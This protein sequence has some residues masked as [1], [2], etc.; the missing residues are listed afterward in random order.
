M[1]VIY[2][3]LFVLTTLVLLSGCFYLDTEIKHV[4]ELTETQV[5]E[6]KNE[7]SFT[8]PEE[9]SIIKAKFANSK[10]RLFMVF[11]SGIDDVDHFIEHNLDFKVDEKYER[12]HIVV[13]QD[14]PELE[15][16]FTAYYY[17]GIHN[18]SRREIYVYE[19]D[20]EVMVEMH[21]Q[22]IVSQELVD[23]FYP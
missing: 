4:N 20:G 9:A 1:K 3:S 18:G 12:D 13:D 14:W 2:T 15:E 23:M 8:L 5:N 10:D 22:G 19:I 17:F 7:F 6:I 16:I 11:I 21:K